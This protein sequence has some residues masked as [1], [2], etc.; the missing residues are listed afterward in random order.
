MLASVARPK[1]F[2]SYPTAIHALAAGQETPASS[3]SS[4][5]MALLPPGVGWTAHLAPFQRSASGPLPAA[6]TK[7]K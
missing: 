7:S 3:L 5:S 1:L 6:G 2:G 4:L